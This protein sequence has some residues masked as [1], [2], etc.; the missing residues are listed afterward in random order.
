MK[1]SE[2]IQE[3]SKL[4]PN[5][6]ILFTKGNWA[7]DLSVGAELVSGYSVGHS[8]KND[9][10][11]TRPPYFVNDKSA[12]RVCEDGRTFLDFRSKHIK[13]AIYLRSV[14]PDD[15]AAFAEYQKREN[16]KKSKQIELFSEEKYAS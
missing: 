13:Q 14:E 10:F 3:L 5:L 8:K 11:G 7:S 15:R 16:D 9:P 12:N 4:D 1:I 2:L 6:D